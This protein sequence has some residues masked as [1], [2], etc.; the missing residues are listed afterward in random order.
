[1]NAINNLSYNQ[2]IE[3]MLSARESELFVF[4]IIAS[5]LFGFHWQY[6][7]IPL[8]RALLERVLLLCGHCLPPVDLCT[9]YVLGPIVAGHLPIHFCFEREPLFFPIEAD[10]LKIISYLSLLLRQI[11][12]GFLKITKDRFRAV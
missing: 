3:K 5:N 9:T 11:N 4:I 12:V 6:V 8:C 7:S 1:M 10:S 2:I